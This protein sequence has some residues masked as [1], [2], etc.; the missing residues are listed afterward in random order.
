MPASLEVKLVFNAGGKAVRKVRDGVSYLVANGVLITEGVHTGTSGPIFYSKEFIKKVS[1]KGN[2]RPIVRNHPTNDAGEYITA[3]ED[4]VVEASGFGDLMN[5]GG[6][7][8]MKA[9]LWFEEERTKKLDKKVYNALKKGE[10]LEVSTG[11]MLITDDKPGEWKGQK[12]KSSAVDADFDHL[13]IVTNGKGACDNK[14]GCGANITANC[15]GDCQC[16]KCNNPTPI[17][18]NAD[19]YNRI[20]SALSEYVYKTFGYNHYVRDVYPK[21]FIYRDGNGDLFK[22]SYTV[23]DGGDVVI[24]KDEPMKV[25]WVTEYRTADSGKF[26]GNASQEVPVDKLKQH[27]DTLVANKDSGFT[28]EDR[29]F[30]TKKGEP[31]V[32]ARVKSLT[33]NNEPP[34]EKK[35]ETPPPVIEKDDEPQTLEELVAN[36]KGPL[37]K[38]LQ[39]LMKSDESR[40]EKLITA[41]T[42][43]KS[44]KL[45]P[46]WLKDQEVEALEEI[47]QMAGVKSRK[48]AYNYAGADAGDVDEDEL[49]NNEETE[50]PLSIKR[51][52]FS[53]K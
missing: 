51:P 46:E 20:A 28:E 29:E 22:R 48:P 47:A 3:N 31:W 25:K 17:T 8:K 11:F 18:V 7:E 10:P 39:R 14:K 19:S 42:A 30:L 26:V 32:E 40:K 16:E 49:V 36:T 50:E 23:N 24:G 27:I 45:N 1:P 33:G 52:D 4:G 6:D 43:N 37:G 5:V 13:A 15:G 9:Q 12:Y 44:C 53:K 35:K 2:G 34:K 38:A 41:I 21:F